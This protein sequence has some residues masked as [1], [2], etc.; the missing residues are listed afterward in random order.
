MNKY[1]ALFGNRYHIH[2][3]QLIPSM[4]EIILG[5]ILHTV[6]TLFVWSFRKF[7]FLSFCLLFFHF[8]NDI[9][10]QFYPINRS[11]FLNIFPVSFMWSL[12]PSNNIQI[13]FP[14]H[15]NLRKFML[16]IRTAFMVCLNP[17]QVIFRI[18]ARP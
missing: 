10:S 12:K 1:L 5:N 3:N 15:L 9:L 2:T 4:W 6:R 7:I 11:I 8:H 13:L 18:F 14:F 17:S 16:F